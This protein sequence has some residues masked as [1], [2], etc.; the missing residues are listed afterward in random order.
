[1]VQ[2]QGKRLR[3]LLRE[4]IRSRHYSRR[5]EKSY[6][7]W[8]RYFVRFHNMRHPGDMAEPE[9]QAFLTW[10]ATQRNVAAAT[11]NQALNALVFLYGK[12]L[13]KPLGSIGDV[14]RAKRP[15]KLPVVFTHA[16][17][18]S[19]IRQLKAPHRLIAALM[20]GSGLRVVEAL[21][22]R[23]KDLDFSNETITV[24]DGKGAK[25]RV[26][27][28]PDSLEKPLRERAEAIERDVL[29]KPLERRTPVTLPFALS[30]KYPNA[31]RSVGWQWL[32]PSMGLCEDDDGNLV[33]HHLH[34][35]AVQKAVRG[36]VRQA[37]IAKAASCH[38]FRHTFATELLQRGADIRT[39]Q[40]LLGHADLRT[41]QIYT[42]VLG[43]GFAGVRSPLSL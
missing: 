11:Q 27:L 18:I 43:R 15:A 12:V 35:S 26:T 36:A 13:E 33:R 32:F 31:N 24:R 38:T 34:A 39:V 6:W 41:T 3:E 29:A 40:E 2:Q 25:D 17:S 5:T 4:A 28:M 37:K 10:L 8:I 1:M 20:Y 23:I 7:Y 21:R 22:L 30:R 19:V 9:V 42:H 14:T 16:E